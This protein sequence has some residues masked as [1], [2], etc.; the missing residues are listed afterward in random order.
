MSDIIILKR[1]KFKLCVKLYLRDPS[2]TVFES[3]F[4]GRTKQTFIMTYRGGYSDY[5]IGYLSQV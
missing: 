2:R 1:K 4:I 3:D 5:M